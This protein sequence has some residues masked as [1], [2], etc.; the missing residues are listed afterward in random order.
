MRRA[1]LVGLCCLAATGCAAFQP[2]ML[3]VPPGQHAVLGRVELTGLAAPEGTVD[4]Q[5]VD[6][7]FG[8]E[9]SIVLG[10]SEFAIALPPGA[11][12]VA[13]LRAF[14]YQKTVP[15]QTIWDLRLTFEV[16]PDP[17]T[18]VGTLRIDLRFGQDAR[19]RVE[20][21]YE[22]TLRA[23]RTRYGDLPPSAARRLMTPA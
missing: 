19:V 3:G 9:L 17:A 6:G 11:Y 8:H 20:D 22:D 23:L 2:A 21:E 16:G 5:K 15:D 7:T 10:R 1:R 13:R 14:R 12:R 4:I 18:Y